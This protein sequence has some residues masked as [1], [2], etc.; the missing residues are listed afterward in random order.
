MAVTYYA[1]LTTLGAAKLANAAALGTTLQ[2]TQM[3]VGDGNGNVPVPDANRTTLVHEVRRAPLNRLSIDASNAAQIIAEQVIPETVGGWWIREIGLLDSTGTLIAIANC[4][5]SYKPQLAE[6]SGR[7]Q[8]VRM[9]LI[10]NNTGAVELKIDPSVVLA[11]REY[12]DTAIVAAMNR[13]D[14]KASV[15][16]ATTANIGLNGLQTVD[17]VVLVAGDRVLVKN[18]VTGSQNGIYVAAAGAWVRSKDADENAEVTPALTVSV[19]S[20]TTQ[21]DKIWQLTTDAPIIISTTVLVFQDITNGL[22]RLSSPSFTGTPTA[23]TPADTDSSNLLATTKFVNDFGARYGVG[24]YQFQPVWP[25][26]SLNDCANVRSGSYRVIAGITDIPA[27]FGIGSVVEYRIKNGIDGEFQAIQTIQSAQFNKLAW[28]S[29]WGSGT[30]AAPIWAVW[31]EGAPTDS[32]VFTGSPSAPTPLQFDNDA[33]LATTEFVQRALGNMSGYA[34]L[35]GSAAI[36]A[37]LAGKYIIVSVP[38]TLTLPDPSTLPLG[39]MFTIEVIGSNA[40]VTCVGV[41]AGAFSGPNLGVAATSATV[42]DANVS[43]FVVV[44]GQ[45]RV[46]GGSGKAVLAVNGYQKMSSGLIIQWGLASGTVGALTATYPVAFPNAVLQLVATMSDKT[47]GAFGGITLYS[48][49]GTFGSKTTATLLANGSD[50][51]GG[52]SARYIAIGY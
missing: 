30:T 12:V 6:G 35:T 15:R 34:N 36:T 29:A 49:N 21:A 27:G 22:A 20:G 50:Y 51:V 9:V 44:G 43:Q 41:T 42:L 1:I 37:S 23:P 24:V 45:Y 14:A 33:S 5:P 8:T 19:E 46:F 47:T 52:S 16:V 26:T 17:G 48:T 7:T 25:N 28:R 3:A 10:V 4:A 2:I 40:T 31:K 39:T 11:T 13:Q 32:P 18:Q 38:G